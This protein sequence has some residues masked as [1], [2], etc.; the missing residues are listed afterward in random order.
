[1]SLR[2]QC[3]QA[4]DA[5]EP[6]SVQAFKPPLSL[7]QTRGEAPLLDRQRIRR[8]PP[9]AANLKFLRGPLFPLRPFGLAF[10]TGPSSGLGC[11]FATRHGFSL[12]RGH[13]GH[14][15]TNVLGCMA[16][17]GSTPKPARQSLRQSLRR[18]DTPCMGLLYG[19]DSNRVEKM[20]EDAGGGGWGDKHQIH[21]NKI[22][23]A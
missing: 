16:D 22:A 10:A 17:Q 8:S 20:E 4:L 2:S 5:A 13:P 6:S 3:F 23:Y 9:R 1:M 12:S 21:W 19:K 18:K 7:V 14:G 11:G 15:I